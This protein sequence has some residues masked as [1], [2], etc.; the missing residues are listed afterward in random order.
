MKDKLKVLLK[1]FPHFYRARL[2]RK[3]VLSR[4]LDRFKKWEGVYFTWG[5]RAE[6]KPVSYLL[7]IRAIP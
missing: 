3:E 5:Q 6:A 7:Y 4:D 1:R 2:S